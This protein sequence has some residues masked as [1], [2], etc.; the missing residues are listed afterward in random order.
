MPLPLI[1]ILAGAGGLGVGA[2]ISSFL[3]GGKKA[4]S[5][6]ATTTTYHPYAFYQ[7]SYAKQIQ[8]PDYNIIMESPMS[9]IDSTKKQDMTQQPSLQAPI[10]PTAGAGVGAPFDVGSLIPIV[11]IGGV[12]YIAHGLITKKK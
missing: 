8:Y 1:P 3:S 7:P 9:R 10:S 6:G 11:V 5:V 4:A 2:L 12:V